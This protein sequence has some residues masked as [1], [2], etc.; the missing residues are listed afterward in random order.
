MK[1]YVNN[2]ISFRY[3][4]F[5][6]NDTSILL[7]T[8]LSGISLDS[9]EILDLIESIEK[10]EPLDHQTPPPQQS[11]FIEHYDQT[12]FYPFQ[13]GILSSFQ[14]FSSKLTFIIFAAYPSPS[15]VPVGSSPLEAK[16][17]DSK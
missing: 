15:S 3:I 4:M 13:Q 10:E 9:D 12:N 11:T 16:A 17:I 5:L 14:L 6:A 7:D 2:V 8:Q 1:K